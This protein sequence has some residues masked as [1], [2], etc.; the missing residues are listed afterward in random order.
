[1]VERLPLRM[2][3]DYVTLVQLPDEQPFGRELACISLAG[4]MTDLLNEAVHHVRRCQLRT[5]SDS[6]FAAEGMA[7]AS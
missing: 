6:Y 5:H 4:V 2:Q 1:M 7:S 3:A